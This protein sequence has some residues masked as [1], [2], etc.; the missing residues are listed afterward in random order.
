MQSR[1]LKHLK[2]KSTIFGTL[3]LTVSALLSGIAVSATP[4]TLQIDLN[5]VGNDFEVSGDSRIAKGSILDVLRDDKRFR[6]VVQVLEE[7]RGLRDELEKRE[8]KLTFFAPTD[9][10]WRK[11]EDVL[12][13]IRGDHSNESKNGKGDRD[14]DRKLME[15]VLRYHIVRDQISYKD[16]YNTQ[17]LQSD[18]RES[19]LG[20][21]F[22][23]IGVAEFAGQ[24]YLNMYALVCKDEIRA[25]N[26]VIYALDNIL[27]P[28]V[29]TL[30]SEEMIGA[31]PC[32]FSTFF[33]AAKKTDMLKKLEQEKEMTIF[34]PVNSAWKQLGVQNMVYLFSPRGEKDLKRIVQYHMGKEVVYSTNMM[35]DQKIRIKSFMRDEEIEIQSREM[36]QSQYELKE[37]NQANKWV[38]SVN[39][40]EARILPNFNEFL[41]ANGVIHPINSVLIPSDINL[42]YAM[43]IG[44][45][46]D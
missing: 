41:A 27:I 18:L 34:A 23:K 14:D 31:L 24:Y 3:L 13:N 30:N 25:E 1:N 33:V 2:M 35:K 29:T 4:L 43:E 17:L 6:K 21:K 42:P 32:P 22:Q 40:G 36:S 9:E 26:G 28:P 10:A 44:A 8:R 19:G 11:I 12:D 46:S 15:D 16:L 7:N 38:F 39:K 45:S 37:R 5:T 20:D